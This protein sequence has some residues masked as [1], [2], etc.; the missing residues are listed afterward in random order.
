MENYKRHNKVV[1]LTQYHIVWSPC[2]RRC[3]LVDGVK[4][5]L[6]ELIRMVCNEQQAEI[7]AM[8][9]MPDHIHLF[10]SIS[11]LLPIYKLIKA[12]KGRT[13]NIIRKEFEHIHRMPTLWS[14]SFFVSTIGQV[15]E[16]TVKKYIEMQWNKKPQ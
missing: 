5:R 10:V 16:E 13:S 9:I 7:K 8:E 1:Y 12:V 3:V 6:E 11:Y 15:S 4:T 2:Y 14:R